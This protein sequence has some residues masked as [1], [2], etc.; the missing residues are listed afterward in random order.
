[1]KV[2]KDCYKADA[3]HWWDREAYLFCE[4]A[5]LYFTVLEFEALSPS[6]RNT[7]VKCSFSF[8]LGRIVNYSQKDKSLSNES[9]GVRAGM[10]LPNVM[11]E[12]I[13]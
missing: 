6:Y 4:E 7:S 11:G 8:D 9:S 3:F 2:K 13:D 1:M 12:L 10:L 5:R